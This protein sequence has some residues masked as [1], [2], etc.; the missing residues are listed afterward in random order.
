MKCKKLWEEEKR[1]GNTEAITDYKN[2]KSY[3]DYS[4]QTGCLGTPLRRSV[5]W[6]KKMAIDLL[7]TT[8]VINAL[9]L[10]KSVTGN[11]ISVIEF[12]DN[13]YKGT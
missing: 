3:I 11:S 8:L 4:D 6:Y 1:N 9:F 5:K 7:L 10:F 13:L 12:R 2:G